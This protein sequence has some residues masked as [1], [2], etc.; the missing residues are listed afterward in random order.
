M[1]STSI[2]EI[3]K[4]TLASVLKRFKILNKI[5]ISSKKNPLIKNPYQFHQ[6]FP[7]PSGAVLRRART[8][9][10]PGRGRNCTGQRASTSTARFL[11]RF[12]EEAV[13][14]RLVLLGRAAR[15]WVATFGLNWSGRRCDG[16]HG[17]RGVTFGCRGNNGSLLARTVGARVFRIVRRE[18]GDAALG[19]VVRRCGRGAG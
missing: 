6:L 17:H 15:L 2:E 13:Q 4:V 3:Q 10:L 7:R 11:R 16:G 8:F 14:R 9:T 18:Q 5:N 19:F 1:Q 12:F